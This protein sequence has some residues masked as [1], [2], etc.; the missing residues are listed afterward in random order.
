M[1]NGPQGVGF[2][3]FTPKEE[4]KVRFLFYICTSIKLKKAQ[5]HAHFKETIHIIDCGRRHRIGSR[6][7]Y[8]L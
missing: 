6:E 5:D 3:N 4:V 7:L 8:R 1:P 2:G